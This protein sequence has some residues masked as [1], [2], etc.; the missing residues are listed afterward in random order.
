MIETFGQT[1][2]LSGEI[3][4]KLIETL[5]EGGWLVDGFDLDLDR[6]GQAATVSA[7]L[8]RNLDPVEARLNLFFVV[9]ELPEACKTQ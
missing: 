6:K 4:L 5:S 1:T 9:G 8:A 2:Q 7:Y 3:N